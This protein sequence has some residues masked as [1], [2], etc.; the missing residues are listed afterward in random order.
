M[1]D[2]IS[3]EEFL[4]T[5]APRTDKV[6]VCARNDL[7]VRHRD[8][9]IA[10]RTAL[11]VR[12]DA[13]GSEHEISDE[14]AALL[15]EITAVE[16]EQEQYTLTFEL[17]A[18]GAQAWADLLRQ[19]PPT[20]DQRGFAHN[21][22]TF[23]PAAVAACS[24]EPKLTVEQASRMFST[25]ESGE[26]SKLWIAAV[27]LNELETPHPKLPAAADLLRARQPSAASPER[28]GSLAGSSSAGSGAP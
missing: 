15:E 6:R 17:Q 7:V 25:F 21:P 11:G 19:H 20:K 4:A 26:W 14:A 22:D 8:L 2:G 23:P 28:E 27:S 1:T 16:A 12:P 10:A 5:A 9:T 24:E 18:I 13:L 3:I